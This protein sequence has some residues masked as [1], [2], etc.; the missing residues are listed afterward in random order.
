MKFRL[1]SPI[2]AIQFDGGIDQIAGWLHALTGGEV[3][4]RVSLVGP[5]A[6]DQLRLVTPDGHWCAK[7]GDW[8]MRDAHGG[9]ATM[10][11]DAFASTFEPAE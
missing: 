6:R 4:F 5:P 7:P 3:D 9:I 10:N 2:D 11:A 8:V 1:K